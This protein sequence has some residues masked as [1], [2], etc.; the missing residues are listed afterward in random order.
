MPIYVSI[1]GLSLKA[2]WHAPR[3][4]WHATRCYRDAQRARGCLKADV[5][6]IGGVQH[7]LTVWES[8][9][10]AMAY[11]RSPAHAKA[12]RV[13]PKIATGWAVGFEA[14]TAPTWEDARRIWENSGIEYR[15]A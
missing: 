5:C 13:F 7:T 10:A 4:W 15:A 9:A 3:F 12:M 11:V 14:E 2:P 8:R 1:T 6:E